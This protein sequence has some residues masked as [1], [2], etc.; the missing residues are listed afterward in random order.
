VAT[1][2]PEAIYTI[3]PTDPAY[4]VT[5][6]R[7]ESFDDTSGRA[8]WSQT[9]GYNRIYYNGYSMVYGTGWY[10]PGHVQVNPYGYDTYW[11]YPYSY[12][13]GAWY[14][15]AFGGYGFRGYPGYYPY[16]TGFSVTVDKPEK[17]WKWDIEDG[18]RRVYE[19]APQNYIG[20]GR[21]ILPDGSIYGGEE[22]QQPDP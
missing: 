14:N 22:G 13:Y 8:A 10:Y 7:L 3:P 21:Y 9:S 12:G 4:N 2:V 19:Y 16:S 11:R 1:E 15:P 20:S 5:F 17:D 6:V 18:Q